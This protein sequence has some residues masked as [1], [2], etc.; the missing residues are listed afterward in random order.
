MPQLLLFDLD[1]PPSGSRPRRCEAAAAAE[2][3]RIR[4]IRQD[5]A[6]WRE[7]TGAERP[8]DGST[9][10]NRPSDTPRICRTR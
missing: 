4:R 10:A 8:P 6:H 2:S 5:S 3:T 1:S 7:K 9:E